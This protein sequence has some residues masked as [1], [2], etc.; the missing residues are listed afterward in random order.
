MRLD[1]R[2][3]DRQSKADP[4][5]LAI[6]RT[7]HAVEGLQYPRQLVSGIPGPSSSI[8]ISTACGAGRIAARARLPYFTALSSKLVTAR[9]KAVGWHSLRAT[10]PVPWRPA[11]PHQPYRRQRLRGVP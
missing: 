8:V 10:P 3:G 1:D 7:F 5:G 11:I 2:E 6:S 4:A 9:F